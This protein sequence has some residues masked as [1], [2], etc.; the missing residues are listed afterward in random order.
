MLLLQ[1]CLNGPGSHANGTPW[2]VQLQAARELEAAR[3]QQHLLEEDAARQLAN[4]AAELA[5]RDAALDAADEDYAALQEDV[6]GPGAGSASVLHIP[7][8]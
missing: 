6:R 5:A 7:N 4:M 1:F 8:H 3:V 2:C